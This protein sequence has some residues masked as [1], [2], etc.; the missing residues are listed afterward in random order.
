MRMSKK[1]S[2]CFVCCLPRQLQV[3][4]KREVIENLDVSRETL[5]KATAEAM[6]SRVSDL[7]ETIEVEWF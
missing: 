4:V 3:K 1:L 2:N 5:K 7:T 6:A